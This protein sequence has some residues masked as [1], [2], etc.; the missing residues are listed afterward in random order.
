M[1][2]NLVRVG[3]V[4]AI[5]SIFERGMKGTLHNSKLMHLRSVVLDL[6]VWDTEGMEEQEEISKLG[7]S[8]LTFVNVLVD[9]P[10]GDAVSLDCCM[11]HL[12]REGGAP[13]LG[14]AIFSDCGARV[15]VETYV[16]EQYH[17]LLTADVWCC[18][19]SLCV[20]MVRR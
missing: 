10:Q 13:H 4:A 18:A 12:N 9:A 1:L 8:G 7:E 6:S 17:Q 16:P 5:G 19:F 15:A 14:K 20:P 11:E 3:R 2:Y